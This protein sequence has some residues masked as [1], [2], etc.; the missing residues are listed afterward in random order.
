MS[1]HNQSNASGTTDIG[2]GTTDI[3]SGTKPPPPP[4][5]PRDD[6]DDALDQIDDATNTGGVWGRPR[7]K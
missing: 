4:P 1:N 5:P 3:G 2:S 6:V 7:R